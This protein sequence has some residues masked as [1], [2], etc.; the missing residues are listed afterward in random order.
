MITAKGFIDQIYLDERRAARLSCPPDLRPGPGQYL[1][2]STRSNPAVPLALPV[3]TTGNYPGGFY[4]AAPLPNGANWLPGTALDLRGPLGRGFNL[5][6][7]ARKVALAAP[8]GNGTRVLALLE[9]ALAQNASVVMCCDQPPADLPAALE[10]LPAA[11]LLEITIWADYLACQ[12][13][14]EHL[15]G[16]L[17]LLT[18]ERSNMYPAGR[19][20][21]TN[22]IAPRSNSAQ[23]LVET[24]VPCAG[25][26]DCGVCAVSLRPGRDFKLACKDG[27]VFDIY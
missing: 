24:P 12:V 3:Y 19:P 8:V 23:V 16:L 13:P 1:L 22:S 21:S 26:A 17:N 18:P 4:V 11:A 15:P 7:Q 10:I 25:L 9:P 14:R 6:A 20:S 5:P 27:P 2:A